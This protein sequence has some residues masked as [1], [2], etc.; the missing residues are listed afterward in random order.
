MLDPYDRP[1]LGHD[2][3]RL[4][5][6]V[7]ADIDARLELGSHF[8]IL[9]MF[10]ATEAPQAYTRAMAQDWVDAQLNEPHAYV[11]EQAGRLVGALRLHSI[12]PHDKRASLAI[13]LLN[14]STLGQGIGTRAMSILLDHVFGTL[15]L[16]RI[17]IRVIDYNDRAIAAYKK[18][19]FQI[20]GRKREAAQV[21][22]ARHD[23]IMMGLLTHEWKDV[24]RT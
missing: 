6:P 21:G 22:D 4:R 5:A 16:H 7:A 3:L 19:G 2:D 12:A 20:E 10:G 17:S 18:L 13:A 14:P 9:R 8:E 15:E 23:D 1:V 24:T 11:I